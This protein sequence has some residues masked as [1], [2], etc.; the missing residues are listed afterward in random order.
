MALKREKV[1]NEKE[2]RG[3]PLPLLSEKKGKMYATKGGERGFNQGK[4]TA[5]RIKR[6]GGKKVILRH[7]SSIGE[8]KRAG[9]RVREG[10]LLCEGRKIEFWGPQRRKK[11][12]SV[13]LLSTKKKKHPWGKVFPKVWEN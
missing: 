10:M 12:G 3:Y 9:E 6:G 13:P 5:G 7:L 2:K 8:K 11:N 4:K 1:H